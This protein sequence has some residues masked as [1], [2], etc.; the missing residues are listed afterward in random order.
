MRHVQDIQRNALPEDRI[1]RLE[2]QLVD[3][4][5]KIKRLRAKRKVKKRKDRAV[6]DD[7]IYVSVAQLRRRY[8]GISRMWLFR[9]L[10]DDPTFPK[11]T[12][13]GQGTRYWRIAD[14]EVW[15]RSVAAKSKSSAA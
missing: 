3:A 10:R 2:Q 14:L 15:E 6:P 5:T 9:R 7:A 13:L 4:R 11:P 1:R 8:G 12:N